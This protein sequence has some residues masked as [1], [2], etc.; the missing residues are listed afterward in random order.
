M[1]L[2]VITVPSATNQQPSGLIIV[3]HGFGGNA[4]QLASLAPFLNL[5]EYQF[6][7]PDA[8]FTNPYVAGGRMWYEFGKPGGLE[9]PD[10]VKSQ[11]MLTEWLKSLEGSTGVPLS[12]T[13]LCGFS[14]G[15]AMTLDVGLNLPLAGLVV[16]SGYLHPLSPK[17]DAT[18]PPVLIVHGRQDSV[19]PLSAA[20]KAR[21]ALT[22]LGVS[23][24]YQEFDME[25]EVQ[26]AALEVVR[27]F[28]K[29]NI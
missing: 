26:P 24:Q 16:L 23:V 10:L 11:Q 18:Y 25:H 29:A 20:Q 5:P 2:S 19:V 8:P 21:D 6:L 13:I 1:S 27:K 7:V 22:A 12:R 28:V 15:G 14:Q 9:S 3:L 17:P 4:Q